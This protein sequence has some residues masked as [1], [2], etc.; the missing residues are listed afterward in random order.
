M[1]DVHIRRIDNVHIQVFAIPS[2]RMGMMEHFSRFAK[3]Y[4][5]SPEFK[6]K[7]WNGKIHFF[8][9]N[10]GL[11]YAGLIKEVLDYCHNDGLSVK[12]DPDVK[13]MFQFPAEGLED[14]LKNLNLHAYG[15][16][17]EFRDY[18][19]DSIVKSIR[20]KRR[21]IQ[22]PTSSGKS[23]IIYGIARYLQDKVFEE[24]DRI[25]IVVPNLSLVTQLRSD[26]VDYSVLN[27]WD[28]ASNVGIFTGEVKENDKQIL[29]ST[30]QSIQKF[31]SDWFEGFRCLMFDEVHQANQETSKSLVNIGKQC[32]A[33]FRIGL[34]GS[35]DDSDETLELTLT[36]LFGFKT[37]ATT[38]KQLMDDGVVAD[39]KIHCLKLTHVG[40]EY[41]GKE[42]KD[43][44]AW[45]ASNVRRNQFIVDLANNCN[46][47]VLVLFNLVQKHGKPLF[48][49]AQEAAKT[50]GKEVFFVTG[51]TDTD[52]R[53]KTRQI[54]EKHAGCIIL[55]SY[56]VFSTGVSVR[57]INSMIFASP[58][59]SYKR[60]VQSIGRGLRVSDTKTR[61]DLFDLF[62]HLSG[63]GTETD[64]YNYTMEH[65]I[66]RMKIYI[67]HEFDY[68]IKG[69]ILK[70][71]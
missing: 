36:G 7:R 42:Y 70:D 58:S 34:S 2:I 65:F 16:S 20:S 21:I 62:D 18:Q 67:Q 12:V 26:F 25:L 29:I 51:G 59:K 28:V 31:D 46:G 1:T 35:I 13:E 48:K 17:I 37:V 38:T 8:R 71:A 64:R 47:N 30:W 32:N 50:T 22:S 5:F 10:T 57:N 33:E 45:L 56:G 55:A 24:H 40:K 61:C 3:N 69:V 14:Y 52:Q 60:V 53:E 63:E 4:Y 43:E 44:I 39:L 41:K 15:S 68:K 49:M 66:E 9:Y 27:G 11:V 19:T 54:A 23:S 6:A